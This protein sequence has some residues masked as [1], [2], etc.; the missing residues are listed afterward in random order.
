MANIQVLK[1]ILHIHWMGVNCCIKYSMQLIKF[2]YCQFFANLVTSCVARSGLETSVS[3]VKWCK[4]IIRFM[5]DLLMID[6]SIEYN[7]VAIV[8]AICIPK[9]PK[10]RLDD[11][12]L[13][14]CSNPC[15]LICTNTLLLCT[16]YF[17]TRN[18]SQIH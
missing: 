5:L 12:S 11:Q 4:S 16:H 15:V 1:I 8:R 6:S 9:R 17:C 18:I 3:I 13:A 7:L 14:I 2:I 10:D